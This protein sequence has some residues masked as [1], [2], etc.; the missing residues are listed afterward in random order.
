MPYFGPQ[1]QYVLQEYK[2]NHSSLD[3]IIHDY[4]QYNQYQPTLLTCYM[5]LKCNRGPSPACLDWTEICDEKVDCL[6]SGYDEEHCWQLEIHQCNENEHACSHGQCIPLAFQFDGSSISDCLDQ[7][8]EILKQGYNYDKDD[9][10]VSEP[11]FKTEDILCPRLLVE[12]WFLNSLTSSCAQYRSNLLSQ[13]IF[14]IKPDPISNE[15][16]TALK[17][18]INLPVHRDREKICSTLCDNT[19]CNKLISQTCPNITYVPAVPI[20]FGHIY[21]AFDKNVLINQANRIRSK[22]TYFCYNKQLLYVSDEIEKISL[23]NNNTCGK[24]ANVRGTAVHRNIFEW[25][26]MY[27][28]PLY[29]YLRRTAISID[30]NAK[31]LNNSVMYKCIDWPKYI[32][33]RHLFDDTP[34][35]YYQDDENPSKMNRTCPIEQDQNYFKCLTTNECI[36]KRFV[37]DK[38]CHCT[39]YGMNQCDDENLEYVYAQNTV[40]FPAICDGYTHM[41]LQTIEGRNEQTK[42]I[43]DNG[44]PFI[45]TIIATVS[46]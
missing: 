3:E 6:D 36:P 2:S 30:E 23:S 39:K 1:C 4:Y 7:S 21:L 12:D 40:S 43:V 11:T 41:K 26:R 15:C 42:Q 18:I 44:H 9:Y 13:A 22:P 31:F 29:D 25:I 17:C 34:D 10:P 33:K 5:H 37:N 38:T 16:W 28:E 14:S 24:Y 8:D 35:C 45:F 27:V 32:S 19:A 20:L 46:A